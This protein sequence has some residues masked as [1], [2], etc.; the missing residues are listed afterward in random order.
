LQA[1]FAVNP[2]SAA[3]S[4]EQLER[5][6]CKRSLTFSLDSSFD[7]NAG[8]EEWFQTNFHEQQS[9]QMYVA[10]ACKGAQQGIEAA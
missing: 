6:F 1:P 10:Q 5:A 7:S 8:D 2:N 3:S 4:C 9:E